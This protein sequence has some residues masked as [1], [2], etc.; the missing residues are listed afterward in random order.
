[1][2]HGLTR[3]AI[4]RAGAALAEFH[5][6]RLGYECVKTPHYSA[7]GDFWV[8]MDG[9]PKRVEVKT[10]MNRNWVIRRKQIEAVDFCLFI[11]LT[12]ACAWLV[13]KEAILAK[14]EGRDAMSVTDRV[15][16]L[17]SERRFHHERSFGSVIYT[18]RKDVRKR[19]VRR[20]LA[21]GEVKEYRYGFD[22]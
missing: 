9:A 4:G 14:L 6:L 17:E 19:I 8:E 22:S 15:A 1:M 21:S 12:E 7:S 18:K 5:F 20:R 16:D 3:D 11:A 10:S 2:K 13:S